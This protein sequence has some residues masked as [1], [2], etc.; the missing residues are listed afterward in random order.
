MPATPANRPLASVTGASKG[1]G[2][3]IAR[4]LASR[5]HD[6]IGTGRGDSIDT[7]AERLR[8]QG[9]GV[10]PLR[11]DLFCPLPMADLWR[12]PHPTRTYRNGASCPR[13]NLFASP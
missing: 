7:V 6:V 1:I 8:G 2:T 3:E 4:R 9:A 10:C 5:G 11:A 13:R 12:H